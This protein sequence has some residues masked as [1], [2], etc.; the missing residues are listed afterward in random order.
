MIKLRALEPEDVVDIDTA[1][2]DVGGDEQID[3]A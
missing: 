2:H 3:I 1:G